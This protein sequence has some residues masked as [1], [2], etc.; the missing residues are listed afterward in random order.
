MNA[1]KA[2]KLFAKTIKGAARSAARAAAAGK[3][4]G[5]SSDV[6]IVGDRLWID[7]EEIPAG[8][9]SYT[10]PNGRSYT[11]RREQGGVWVSTG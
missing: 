9:D 3:A 8:L 11:I 7:G 10:A 4:P 2:D 6:V 5:I 1:M